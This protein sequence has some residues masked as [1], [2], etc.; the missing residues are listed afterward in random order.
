MTWLFKLPA[1]DTGNTTCNFKMHAS[2]WEDGPLNVGKKTHP[3]RSGHQSDSRGL[4][5]MFFSDLNPYN[6]L[7]RGQ[8]A[9]NSYEQLSNS[10]MSASHKSL[11]GNAIGMLSPSSEGVLIPLGVR[12]EC[13]L[14][15]WGNTT[16]MLYHCG[17]CLF[18]LRFLEACR[19]ARLLYP[20]KALLHM[21]SHRN[22]CTLLRRDME[23]P[24]RIAMSRYAF[25]S[26]VCKYWRPRVFVFLFLWF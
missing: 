11:I 1:L 19:I 3:A 6:G 8:F 25:V 2:Q 15:L 17:I 26:H 10:V 22:P 18:W 7:Q 5:E 9:L 4:M 14:S 24:S 20:R 21:R 23:G 12:D 13:C 16:H